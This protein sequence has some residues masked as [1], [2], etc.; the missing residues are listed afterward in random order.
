MSFFQG[1]LANF[2]RGWGGFLSYCP[3]WWLRDESQA[4]QA[5][6]WRGT[7]SAAGLANKDSEHL[8]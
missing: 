8:R 2:T 4:R 3:E 1:R 6:M 7:W 5:G